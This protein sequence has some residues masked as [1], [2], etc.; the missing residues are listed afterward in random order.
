MIQIDFDRSQL[1]ELAK[2][3]LA[4]RMKEIESEVFF[5]DSKQLQKFANMSW[6]SIVTHFLSDPKFPAIR[7]GHKWLF[8]RGEVE[9]YMQ[10]YYEAVRSSGGDIQK[11]VR[12]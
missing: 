12:K 1:E 4:E 9:A 2:E 5:M 6:N 10:K 11:Y 3:A 8:P 7:L